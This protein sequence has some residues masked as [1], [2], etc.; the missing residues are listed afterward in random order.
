MP[1]EFSTDDL[2]KQDILQLLEIGLKENQPFARH[3]AETVLREINRKVR[4][5]EIQSSAIEIDGK[6][7]SEDINKEIREQ[8]DKE[9]DAA[10]NKTKDSIKKA[11]ADSSKPSPTSVSGPPLSI[12][13]ILGQTPEM[14]KLTQIK[15]QGL[16]RELLDKIKQGLPEK[17]ELGKK[18]GVTFNSLFKPPA[19]ADNLALSLGR[20]RRW[21][22]L[23]NSL[24]EKLEKGLPDKDLKFKDD[25]V[26]FNDIFKP[27]AGSNM[28]SLSLSRY[29]RWNNFQNSLLEKLE[30]GL[31]DKQLKFKNDGVTFT[32][33]FTPPAAGN[34]LALSL[35]RYRKWNS[36]Q[37]SLLEKLEKGLPDKQLKF[38]NDGVTFTDI[39]SPPAAGNTIALSLGRYRKWNK[40]QNSLLEKIEAGL[41]EKIHLASPG[42]NMTI[43]SLL[44][45]PPSQGLLGRMRWNKLRR[46]LLNKISKG[47]GD[48]KELPLKELTIDTILGQAPKAGLL[49]RLKWGSL[50]RKLL[51][52]ISDSVGSV[53][54]LPIQLSID[55]ILGQ[56]PKA[57]LLTRMKWGSLQRKLLGKIS[58]SVDNMGGVSSRMPMPGTKEARP[59]AADTKEA[60]PK[61]G[62]RGFR[63]LEEEEPATEISGFTKGALKDLEEVLGKKLS[64]KLDVRDNTKGEK[65]DNWMRTLAMAGLGIL[66]GAI[67]VGLSGLFDDGPL[68][69]LKKIVS[70][71]GIRLGTGLLKTF[72]KA[73]PKWM[74]VTFDVMKKGLSAIVPDFLKQLGKK[75]Q[76]AIRKGFLALAKGT[77]SLALKMAGGGL[78]KRAFAGVLKPLTKIFAKTA[79]KKLPFGIGAIFG[80]AFGISRMVKGDITGGLLEFLSGIASIVPGIGT[81]ASIA[82][83]GYLAIRDMKK[84]KEED[85]KP[86]GDGKSMF[87]KI[88]ERITSKIKPMLRYIPVI[89][90]LIRFSEAWGLFKSGDYLKG[91]LSV[92]GAF[93]TMFPGM[94]TA[95]SAGIDG[96]MGLINNAEK[97]Q[98]LSA[99]G[100]EKLT[101]F[102]AF[103]KVVFEKI[104]AGL[105]KLPWWLKK[106]LKFVPGL[107][108]MIGDVDEPGTEGFEESGLTEKE[109][110]RMDELRQRRDTGKLG[111]GWGSKEDQEKELAA[112]EKKAQESARK[113]TGKDVTGRTKTPKQQFGERFTGGIPTVGEKMLAEV[114]GV[115]TA[116]IIKSNFPAGMSLKDDITYKLKSGKEGSIDRNSEE[117]SEIL[118]AVRDSFV[119]RPGKKSDMAFDFIWRKGQGVQK[120]TPDDNLIGVKSDS[121]FNK[122]TAALEGKGA[123]TLESPDIKQLV[124]KTDNMIQ[125]LS[126]IVANTGMGVSGDG[127]ANPDE[128]L[129]QSPS[130]GSTGENLDGFRDP[131]YILR[132]RAWDRIRKGYAVL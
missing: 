45:S 123:S 101:I 72:G 79:L 130:L 120:F 68:K 62:R 27:P 41:P 82:I 127:S 77:K 43:D 30:K 38:K 4:N 112:L 121:D 70:R 51:G 21:N 54:A 65:P 69:G 17:I 28:M 16:T 129:G 22:K 23:Q 125:L 99:S 81:V 32:D 105:N 85:V 76:F 52:K 91:L 9:V 19:A 119:S 84:G 131:A 7:I 86:K 44:G 104:K 1:E 29:R 6:G 83:D 103:K 73:L 75:F 40:L 35:G 122:L 39:F 13:N 46:E 48:L 89:G 74:G 31:P 11:V 34:T 114:L 115:K 20:Y 47:V 95:L 132:S 78:L 2:N 55:A 59:K 15:F 87:Q 61:A 8:L 93:A 107:K 111:K 90:T 97:E 10:V 66:G 58:D 18:D 109:A 56:S 53:E 36:L 80:L 117:G 113:A 12:S 92:G 67:G 110:K 64:T 94:G 63:T 5:L 116:D 71:A 3:F 37:N 50:Q 108:T 128:S 124:M 26:S 88:K 14:S 24:L 126:M 106:A 42:E 25:G 98:E 60:R 100:G 102:G 49:T 33:I 57:G 118:K 96:L